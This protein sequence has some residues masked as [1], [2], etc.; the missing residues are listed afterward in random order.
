MRN[1]LL[2]AIAAFLIVLTPI[3]AQ[4][5]YQTT[6]PT[7]ILDVGT[8]VTIDGVNPNQIK[9]ATYGDNVL[10]VIAAREGGPLATDYRYLVKTEGY[11]E[12]LAFAA[13][14]IGSRLTYTSG[15]GALI[16]ATTDDEPTVGVITSTTRILV[17]ISVTGSEVDP[18]WSGSNTTTG[19]ISR[20]GNVSTTGGGTIT[21]DGLL[22][23][24]ANL[25]VTGTTT[26]NSVAAGATSDN[27]L[28][29]TGAGLLR[30]ISMGDMLDGSYF[31]NGGNT[32]GGPAVVGTNDNFGLSFETNNTTWMSISNAGAITLDNLS[33]TNDAG[34]TGDLTVTGTTNLIDAVTF[35][36]GV[37]SYLFPTTRGANGQILIT[38][39]SGNVTWQ[40]ATASLTAGM[41]IDFSGTST[42]DIEPV[43]DYVQTING[44]AGND[45]LLNAPAGQAL[46]MQTNGGSERMRIL[47]N[48]NVGIGTAAPTYLFQVAGQAYINGGNVAQATSGTLESG[49]NVRTAANTSL[50][51]P[52]AFGIHNVI[53]QTAVTNDV[54]FVRGISSSAHSVGGAGTSVTGGYFNAMIEATAAAGA[55]AVVGVSA[56]AEA[57]AGA[58]GFTNAQ[59]FIGGRFGAAGA[60]IG[61][62]SG[63][64][65]LIHATEAHAGANI[66]GSAI[67]RSSADMNV[68]LIGVANASDVQVQTMMG[69]LSALPGEY[70]AGVL[71]Y[72]TGATAQD[73]AIFSYAGTNYFGGFVVLNSV[74][75]GA[76]T[77]MLLTRNTATGLVGQATASTML[78]GSFFMNGGNSFGGPATVGTND[79]QNLSLEANNITYLTITPAGAVIILGN[80]TETGTTN[81]QGIVTMGSGVTN[82]LLPTT[83]G[84]NGQILIT[85]GSGNVTWQ[86][87]SATT[88][89]QV[90]NLYEVAGPTTFTTGGATSVLSTGGAITVTGDQLIINA[91]IV[92]SDEYAGNYSG[93]QVE[94]TIYE[95]ANVRATKRITLRGGD[96]Y[97][98]KDVS[99]SYVDATPTASVYSVRCEAIT[100][101][102]GTYREGQMT[103]TQIQN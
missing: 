5:R 54:R 96:F 99:I 102:G 1:N 50:A 46:I 97:E 41:D 36:T 71:A 40:N 7:D 2:K 33:V 83:R 14:D 65:A 92:I 9:A 35:G 51:N 63:I 53:N 100:G 74:A 58:V 75:A 66:G 57:Y 23:A 10:G 72:N 93:T 98:D 90:A 73:F 21:S 77:D 15:T 34:I 70:S 42:I 26:L 3:F 52:Y 103:I 87:A 45:L 91:G 18:T 79:N 17:N 39:G 22:T 49:L 11:I 81:L 89:D 84:A 4:I 6:N 48:G 27:L 43:L 12:G 86:D 78:G 29:L 101:A 19:A 20:S 60:N 82:Y 25:Y 88:L 38:D 37:T 8:V 13:G 30:Q 24:G 67:A 95:G 47:S 68:G 64:G 55:L 61:A 94:I 85:D 62:A 44:P 69:T 31:K 16:L 80:L 59:A 32:F 76:S 56:D 28:V